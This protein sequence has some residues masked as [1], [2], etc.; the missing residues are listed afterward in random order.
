MVDSPS[1]RERKLARELRDARVTA[2]LAGNQ[3]ASALG[4]SASKVSRIET[5]RIGISGSDLDTLITLY[6]L[7]DEHAAY[8]R[9][10]A[11]TI[12]THGWWDAYADSLSSG[13]AGLLR[14]EAGSQALRTYCALIPHPLLMTPDYIRQVVGA[15]WQAPSEQEVER[16]IRVCLRRQSVLEQ[17]DPHPRLILSA[18]LDEAV[19]RRAA[20]A[21]GAPGAA[22]IRRGQLERLLLVSDWPNISLQVLP[23][24]AGIPPV[25]AG[26]FSVL[27]SRA[28]G[29]PDV[30]YL[31]NKTRISFVDAE[32]EVHRYARDF[33]QLTQMA[34]STQE[35]TAF[36]RSLLTAAA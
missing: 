6:D 27:E 5:G 23:F 29:A 19:L 20:T 18:V 4:W 34:L 35:S 17:D 28:T 14:L 22:A 3:V 10:L 36:I 31:E 21:P 1:I 24:D 26:S 2:Q 16:R 11:P 13:Y 12:R 7:P 33:H 15:T 8:L 9:R 25:S 32:A 30:I